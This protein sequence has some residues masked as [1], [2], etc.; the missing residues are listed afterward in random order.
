M[1]LPP[2]IRVNVATVFPAR[3]VG[4]TYLTVVKANGVY[5]IKADYTLL[6]D[7]LAVPDPTKKEIVIRDRETNL[8]NR[9]SMS[10]LAQA[11]ASLVSTTGLTG[12]ILNTHRIVTAAGDVTINPTDQIILL[13]K[14]VGAATNIILPTAASRNGV[15]VMVKDYKGDAV[16]NN[17]RYQLAGIETIDGFNQATADANGSSLIDVNKGWKMISPLA[18]GGWYIGNA[19]P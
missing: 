9:I 2:S 5:T 13:N 18:S 8:F 17:I 14:T 4:A 6:N 1:T 19:G 12:A 15:P 3:A 10:L 11:A 7:L 16:A